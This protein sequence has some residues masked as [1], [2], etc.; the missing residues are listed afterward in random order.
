M[1]DSKT[2]ICMMA[3]G[4]RKRVTLG[5]P[6][7]EEQRSESL[8]TGLQL[9]GVW[10]LP[11]SK[12]VIVGTYSIWDDGHGACR[13]QSYHE[14]DQDEIAGL[15]EKYDCDALSELVPVVE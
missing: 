3:D 9:T 11:Q 1:S 13:G 2:V 12:S 10:V 6:V 4:S 15:A 5:R 7:I 8:G 14:A